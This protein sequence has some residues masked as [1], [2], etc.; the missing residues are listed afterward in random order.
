MATKF[1]L[2][3]DLSKKG[4]DCCSKV[5][6]VCNSVPESKQKSDN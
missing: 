1:S 5:F 2:L 6:K 3:L 4:T